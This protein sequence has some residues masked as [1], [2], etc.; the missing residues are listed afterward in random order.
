MKTKVAG[1]S[2]E[3]MMRANSMTK[4]GAAGVVFHAFRQASRVARGVAAAV[5]VP[6]DEDNL[7]VGGIR[8]GQGRP[9]MLRCCP[10]PQIP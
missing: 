3:D 7:V 10:M 5:H 9:R 8:A 1:Y 2:W 4:R 6:L